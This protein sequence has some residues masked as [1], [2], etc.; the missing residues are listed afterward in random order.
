MRGRRVR[1]CGELWDHEIG[2]VLAADATTILIEVDADAVGWVRGG[3]PEGT[4]TS[5]RQ[6]RLPWPLPAACPVRI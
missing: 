2:V 1:W 6:V 4:W 3:L 5:E